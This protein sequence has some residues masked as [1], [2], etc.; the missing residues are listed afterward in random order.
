MC[1]H[2][3]KEYILTQVLSKLSKV[4]CPQ[5][6]KWEEDGQNDAFFGKVDTEEEI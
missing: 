1:F 5:G 3:A 2:W 6:I 4:N